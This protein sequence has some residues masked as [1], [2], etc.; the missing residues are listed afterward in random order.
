MC[1]TSY[2]FNQK[3]EERK[4]RLNKLGRFTPLKGEFIHFAHHPQNLSPVHMTHLI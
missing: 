3:I 4:Y 1:R 2:P